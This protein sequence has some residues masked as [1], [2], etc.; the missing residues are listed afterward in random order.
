[1]SQEVLFSIL[2]KK[3]LTTYLQCQKSMEMTDC[4]MALKTELEKVENIFVYI[5]NR[6]VTHTILKCMLTLSA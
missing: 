5:I 6:D 3:L 2:L 4:K 1:M